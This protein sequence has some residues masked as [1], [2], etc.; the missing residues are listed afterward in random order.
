MF[1]VLIIGFVIIFLLESFMKTSENFEDRRMI[2]HLYYRTPESK[3][4]YYGHPW[5]YKLP[6]IEKWIIHNEYPLYKDMG[7][8]KLT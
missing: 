8:P 5:Q 6:Y 3:Y 2:H 7:Y 1:E 4:R